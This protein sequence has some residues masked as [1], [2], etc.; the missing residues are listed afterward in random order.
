[1]RILL[2][3]FQDFGRYNISLTY[4]THKWP[5]NFFFIA[6]FSSSTVIIVLH[7]FWEYMLLGMNEASDFVVKLH[8]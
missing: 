8:N 4:Q 1:M 5:A 6:Q 3:L 2:L 7:S